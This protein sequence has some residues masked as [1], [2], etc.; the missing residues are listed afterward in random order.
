MDEVFSEL[1]ENLL[2]INYI[3]VK[4]YLNSKKLSKRNQDHLYR[5]IDCIKNSPF[6]KAIVG[7]FSSKII[8]DIDKRITE[9]EKSAKEA[10]GWTFDDQKRYDIAIEH[11]E[12]IL[13]YLKV[14][15]MTFKDDIISETVLNDS[16][17]FIYNKIPTASSISSIKEVNEDKYNKYIEI[18][19][20]LDEYATDRKILEKIQPALCYLIHSGEE[21]DIEISVYNHDG[22]A[23]SEVNVSMTNIYTDKSYVTTTDSTGTCKISQ[24]PQGKY[25]YSIEKKGYYPNDGKIDVVD[26]STLNIRLKEVKPKPKRYSV[27][28]IIHDEKGNILSDVKVSMTNTQRDRTYTATTDSSGFCRI[29]NL[30]IGKYRFKVQKNGYNS[31]D[32][33]QY[34]FEDSKLNIELKKKH[35]SLHSKRYYPD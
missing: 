25:Y 26:D 5:H 2:N 7:R 16:C 22:N 14:L 33:R 30:P 29:N 6:D 35:Q 9:C 21:H 20:M 3:Y 8:D 24:L 34:V 19:E 31:H 32:G 23:L 15:H 10:I 12:R 18:L 13:P 28:V 27:D 11:Y 4:K 17:D 1:P